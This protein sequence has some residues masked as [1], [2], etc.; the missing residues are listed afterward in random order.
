MN[1]LTLEELIYLATILDNHRHYTKIEEL[2]C[3]HCAL[4][5]KIEVIAANAQNGDDVVE[6]VL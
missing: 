2:N 1:T 4:R 5:A 6:I 3:K